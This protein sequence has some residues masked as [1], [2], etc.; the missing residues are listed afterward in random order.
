[1]V[2]TP[3]EHSRG[4]A[5]GGCLLWEHL[6]ADLDTRIGRQGVSLEVKAC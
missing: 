2:G 6:E 4:T 1:M 5:Q 3:K